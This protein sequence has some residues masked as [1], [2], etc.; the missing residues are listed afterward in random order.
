MFKQ[1]CLTLLLCLFVNTAVFSQQHI[2]SV[3]RINCYDGNQIY[4]G[5]GSIVDC[6]DGKVCIITNYHVVEHDSGKVFGNPVAIFPNGKKVKTLYVAGD[7]VS[8]VVV[9]QP[10]GD[11]TGLTALPLADGEPQ[12]EGVFYGFGGSSDINNFLYRPTQFR[13]AQQAQYNGGATPIHLTYLPRQG[14]SGGPV[15]QNNKIVAIVWGNGGDRGYGCRATPIRN[16]IARVKARLTACIGCNIQPRYRQQPQYA[17]PQQPQQQPQQWQ[18]QENTAPVTE[19]PAPPNSAPIVQINPPQ[20]L[21]PIEREAN[22]VKRE[23]FDK[24]NKDL[25]TL[26]ATVDSLQNSVGELAENSATNVNELKA[27]VNLLSQ[28]INNINTDEFATLNDVIE[29][30]KNQTELADRMGAKLKELEERKI[31]LEIYNQGKR[32]GVSEGKR[33]VRF[34]IGKLLEEDKGGDL[35]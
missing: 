33:I 23:E 35:K 1:G 22:P 11:L 28:S 16:L 18:P 29:I 3:C 13:V 20:E 14:D 24:L 27:E 34:D 9:L 32:I 7:A 21:N 30:Q 17:Q 26:V 10:V 12:G 2:N 8:D 31:A 5:S 15:I 6:G 19:M 25:Q 4:S